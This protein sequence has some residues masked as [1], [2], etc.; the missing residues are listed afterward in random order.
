VASTDGAMVRGPR[1][2]WQASIDQ[3]LSHTRTHPA[4]SPGVGLPEVVQVPLPEH[5]LSIK[6]GLEASG[7]GAAPPAPTDPLAR[8]ASDTLP[9]TE[10]AVADTLV[11]IDITDPGAI[12]TPQASSAATN[13]TGTSGGRTGGTL[14]LHVLCCVADSRVRVP[15]DI[16]QA[17]PRGAHGYPHIA[18]PPPSDHGPGTGDCAP[19]VRLLPHVWRRQ[20][21]PVATGSLLLPSCHSS[22]H[23]PRGHRRCSADGARGPCPCRRQW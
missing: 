19:P 1:P 23:G 13:G 12:A 4:P 10:E 15:Q 14:P 17:L 3:V 20:R 18:P 16:N 21:D 11:D 9:A 7:S 6:R 2:S 8:V 22:A 5:L